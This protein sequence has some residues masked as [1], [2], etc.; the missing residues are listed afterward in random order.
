MDKNPLAISLYTLGYDVDGKL[1]NASSALKTNLRT[2]LSQYMMVTDALDIKDAFVV[3]I[4]VKYEVLSLPNYATREVLTRCTEVLKDYFKT[5]KRNINQPLNLSEIYTVLD[6]VRGV[7]T[8]KSVVIKNNT[9]LRRESSVGRSGSFPVQVLS[10][11]FADAWSRF[12]KPSGALPLR[13]TLN[14]VFF[15]EN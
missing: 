13:A 5:S 10:W 6:K 9:V 11:R 8:V 14:V 7:Q 15:V 12:R 4:E 3:N 2:Y 1:V